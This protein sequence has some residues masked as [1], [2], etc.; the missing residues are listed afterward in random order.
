MFWLTFWATL[1]PSLFGSTTL[2]PVT[3]YAT[4]LKLELK[5]RIKNGTYSSISLETCKWRNVCT[6]SWTLIFNITPGL[7]SCGLSLTK[8]M[9]QNPLEA[10]SLSSSW[11]ITFILWNTKFNCA[12]KSLLVVPVLRQVHAVTSSHCIYCLEI[13]LNIIL[14]YSPSSSKWSLPFQNIV[15]ISSFSHAYY[16]PHQFYPLEHGVLL[17]DN[18]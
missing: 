5:N 12:Y 13:R 10:N 6:W 1:F 9:E 17:D 3:N 16:M 11:E 15:S 14:L 18:F 7:N 8:A 2:W 4:E